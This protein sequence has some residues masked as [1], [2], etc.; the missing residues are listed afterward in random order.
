VPRDRS[1]D[2]A[3]KRSRILRITPAG[4]AKL[5]ELSE[6]YTVALAHHL[7]DWSDDE[8]DQLSASS[9][10]SARASATAVRPA[11]RRERPYARVRATTSPKEV[12]GIDHIVR[13]AQQPSHP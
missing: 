1:P 9:P 12:H 10:A 7:G 3:D 2:P 13:P 11:R 5:T 8:V 4:R 6:R